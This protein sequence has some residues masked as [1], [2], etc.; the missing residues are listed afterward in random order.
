VL[1]VI[2]ALGRLKVE[3]RVRE[4]LH[5]GQQRFNERVELV[6]QSTIVLYSIVL[7]R[8]VLYLSIRLY[9][10]SNCA[11]QSEALPVQDTKRD[12]S[13]LERKKRST[14]LTS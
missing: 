11:Q 8:I 14:W 5:V 7:C 1:L 10:A 2:L 3:P 13:S 6:L 4:R 9:S 12:E